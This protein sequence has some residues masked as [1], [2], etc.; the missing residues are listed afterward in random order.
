MTEP[1]IEDRP[2]QSYLAVHREV[3]DGVPAAVDSAF[4][5]LFA[6][7]GEHGVSRRARRS[8]ASTRWEP[9]ART[10]PAGS[11]STAS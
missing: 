9:R 7:L 2:E 8:S 3:T 1:R 4:P 5:A 10:S 11:P 6:W